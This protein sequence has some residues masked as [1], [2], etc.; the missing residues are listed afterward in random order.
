MKAQSQA[1]P[2]T[3]DVLADLRDAGYLLVTLNN[4]SRALN[5]HRIERFR[6]RDYFTVFLS[7]CYLGVKKPEPEI[8]RLAFQLT[9][10]RRSECLFIDDRDLNLECA[11]D[12]GLLGVRFESADQLRGALHDKGLSV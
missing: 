9:Q 10:R 12:E 8:Y 4:E 1:L 11:L 7:S 2:G 6:L 3:L 5:E